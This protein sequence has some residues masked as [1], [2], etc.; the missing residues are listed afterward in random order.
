MSRYVSGCDPPSSVVCPPLPTPPT[1]SLQQDL[2]G[3]DAKELFGSAAMADFEKAFAKKPAKAA[4]AGAPAQA[5]KPSVLESAREQNVGIV[6]KFLKMPLDELMESLVA[7]VRTSKYPTHPPPTLPRPHPLQ[8]FEDDIDS[9]TL[10]SLAT[11]APT[12]EELKKV[13][14]LSDRDV[15]DSAP[16]V[17]YFRRLVDFPR[18]DERLACWITKLE[19]AD[20]LA[21]L[22]RAFELIQEVASGVRANTGLAGVLQLILALG[23]YLNIGSAQAGAKG[24]RIADLEKLTVMKALDGT[25]LLDWSVDF[26]RNRDE[27]LCFFP[28]T[29]PSIK[30]VLQ[31]DFDALWREAD[32]FQSRVAACERAAKK[33]KIAADDG[34]PAVLGKFVKKGVPKAAQAATGAEEAKETLRDLLKYYGE[35]PDCGEAAA[36]WLENLL[37]FQDGFAG[38]YERLQRKK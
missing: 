25:S 16:A 22:Q 14:A 30:A 6:L 4:G 13:A 7:M 37:S 33:E 21:E 15:A 5:K 34:L 32:E 23:N 29:L 24:I 26:I 35:A 3:K 19:F 1:R 18:Y 8:E 9:D 36:K 17:Q 38:A 27:N 12:P 31:I 20:S 28:S 11:I 2:A 10:R